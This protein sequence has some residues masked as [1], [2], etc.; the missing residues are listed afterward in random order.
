MPPLKKL[1]RK[2]LELPPPPGARNST[3]K[4]VELM[5][6]MELPIARVTQ[7]VPKGT[8]VDICI[9]LTICWNLYFVY[10]HKYLDLFTFIYKM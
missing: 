10:F 8:V 6:W 4:L 9:Y 2:G 1:Q 5:L 7:H 3:W